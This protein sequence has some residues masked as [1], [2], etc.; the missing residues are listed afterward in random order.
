MGDLVKLRTASLLILLL[1][2]ELVKLKPELHAVLKGWQ[3]IINYSE[4]RKSLELMLNLLVKTS[5]D[6]CKRKL[7]SFTY[8]ISEEKKRKNMQRNLKTNSI[9]YIFQC[10]S[11]YCLERN[12]S[13]HEI[14]CCC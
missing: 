4:L 6:L 13:P 14:N 7:I 1:A 10:P 5:E 3:N 11:L 12:M 2:W 8:Y 9:S